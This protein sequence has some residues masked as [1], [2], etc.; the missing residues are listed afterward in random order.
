M[1]YLNTKK[2]AEEDVFLVLFYVPWQVVY[3]LVSWKVPTLCLDGGI[4]SPLWLCLVKGVCMFRCNLPPELLAE[5]LGSFTCHCS[6][7]S[8]EKN[9][10]AIPAGIW[11]CNISI[12]I[13][14]SMVLENQQP[15]RSNIIGITLMHNISVTLKMSFSGIGQTSRLAAKGRHHKQLISW[16]IWSLQEQSQ[17]H[18]TIDHLEERGSDRE[19]S[20]HFSLKEQEGAIISQTN[21]RTVS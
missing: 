8:G 5:W 4:V 9:S 11:T 1:H 2:N 10:S 18:N 15:V 17:R 16:K 7:H 12:T 20:Q 21:T 14:G 13:P 3:E 19:S 6:K